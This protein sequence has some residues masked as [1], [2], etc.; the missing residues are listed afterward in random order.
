MVIHTQ[1]RTAI[2]LKLVQKRKRHPETDAVFN[3][4][5]AGDSKK[6]HLS[7]ELLIKISDNNT[8]RFSVYS[9]EETR[10]YQTTINNQ[11]VREKQTWT[12]ILLNTTG[13]NECLKFLPQLASCFP[14]QLNT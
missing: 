6:K 13:L 9:L 11:K 7:F 12:Q 10:F 14:E 5:I 2:H 8:A 1:A 4:Y 3:A